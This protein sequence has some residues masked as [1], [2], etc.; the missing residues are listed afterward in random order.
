MMQMRKK[1]SRMAAWMLAA[2][3][4]YMAPAAALDVSAHSAV[5]MDGNSGQVIW[6]KNS[7]EK[8]LIASTTKIMTALVVLEQTE[9]SDIV[10]VAAEAVGVEGSSMYLKA[11]EKLTVE[12]L[13]YGLMLS[14]GND[15]AVALAMYVAGSPEAFAE[16]MNE[17]AQ[18][19][20]RFRIPILQIRTV[21]ILKRTMPQLEVLEF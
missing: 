18:G 3:L 11:G 21:W 5:L 9:L 14:S 6:E 16:L 2:I 17:K 15:A 13:L 19:R 20:Y 1:M 12:D 8:S 7:N 10:E 4:V